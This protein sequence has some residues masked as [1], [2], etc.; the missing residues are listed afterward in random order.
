MRGALRGGRGRTRGGVYIAR[1][2]PLSIM[3]PAPCWLC[4]MHG[5]SAGLCMQ[6][7]IVAKIGVMEVCH[8]HTTAPPLV[9]PRG[10]QW[11]L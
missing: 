11:P 2:C 6:S 5:E 1:T 7:F 4:A 8:S 9:Q 10:A 3:P